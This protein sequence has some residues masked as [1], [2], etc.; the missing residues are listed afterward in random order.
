MLSIACARALGKT[1]KWGRYPGAT[2]ADRVAV[3]VAQ[4]PGQLIIGDARV[5]VVVAG[6]VLGEGGQRGAVGRGI[7]GPAD[8]DPA[9]LAVRAF[10]GARRRGWLARPR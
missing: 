5:P 7:Q 8:G 9:Q 1:G 4:R 10:T 3:I 6:G 2:V